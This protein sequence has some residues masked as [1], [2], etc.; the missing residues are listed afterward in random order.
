MLHSDRQWGVV[1]LLDECHNVGERFVSEL[2]ECY[3]ISYEVV[4]RCTSYTQ[5][6]RT[7]LL[8]TPHID[9]GEVVLQPLRVGPPV[10]L[11]MNKLSTAAMSGHSFTLVANL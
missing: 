2:S 4:S 3:Q 11:R 7:L 9:S 8:C 1:M 6:R 10:L 5:Q